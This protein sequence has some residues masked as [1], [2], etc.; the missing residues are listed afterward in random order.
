MVPSGH[1]WIF[2]PYVHLKML[3]EIV[4]FA[5]GEGD[6]HADCAGH[7]SVDKRVVAAGNKTCFL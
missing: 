5:S 2:G 6:K 4:I 1:R 3:E 7:C